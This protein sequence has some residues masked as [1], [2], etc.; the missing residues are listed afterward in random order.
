MDETTA[1][2]FLAIVLLVIFYMIDKFQSNN[3][4]MELKQKPKFAHRDKDE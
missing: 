2:L 1:S 3:R 4:I